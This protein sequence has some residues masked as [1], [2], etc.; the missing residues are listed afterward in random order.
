MVEKFGADVFSKGYQIVFEHR[1]VAFE[2]ENIEALQ[3]MLFE[4]IADDEQRGNFI[5]ICLQYL[6]IPDLP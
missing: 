2:P 4:K 5:N 1:E 6:V 3:E